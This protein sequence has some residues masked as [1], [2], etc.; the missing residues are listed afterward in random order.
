MWDRLPGW[1]T[2]GASNAQILSKRIIAYRDC[3]NEAIAVT[4]QAKRG[5]TKKKAVARYTTAQASEGLFK[6]S[7][8]TTLSRL[9]L[10]R[11]CRPGS[12]RAF[13]CT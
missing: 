8:G 9:L 2:A 7:C 13:D 11:S 5:T 12:A 6:T 10:R 3:T 4:P 1:C